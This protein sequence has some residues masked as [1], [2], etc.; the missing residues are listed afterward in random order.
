MK[1]ITTQYYGPLYCG[2]PIWYDALLKKLDVLH[3][4][5]IR[6]VV[7]DWGRIFARD[8][9]DTLDMALPIHSL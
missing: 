6:V 2:I 1:V 3:Y 4:K 7:N 5:S 8:V 9:L